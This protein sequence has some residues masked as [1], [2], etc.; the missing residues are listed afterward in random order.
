[1]GHFSTTRFIAETIVVK[2][3][4]FKIMSDQNYV[5]IPEYLTK[6]PEMSLFFVYKDQ[7]VFSEEF[8]SLDLNKLETIRVNYLNE[9]ISRLR[10]KGLL[11][12]KAFIDK[13]NGVYHIFDS[14]K[15]KDFC[16]H[17]YI[18][19]FIKN[20]YLSNGKFSDR[21]Y[22]YFWLESNHLLHSEETRKIYLQREIENDRFMG[23]INKPL[24]KSN[25]LFNG[26]KTDLGSSDPG[27]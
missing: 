12:E 3:D 19:N 13:F 26:E 7:Q 27:S 16:D 9:E 18:Q 25:G 22:V 6:N 5:D 15:S 4:N 8:R 11:S 24:F 10:D 14:I 17:M 1:M 2:P 23:N 20:S 21:D